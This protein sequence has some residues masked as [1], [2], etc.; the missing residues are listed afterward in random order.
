L[1]EHALKSLEQQPLSVT[2]ARGVGILVSRTLVLQL[3]TAGVTLVLARLLTPADYGLFALAIA[4]QSLAQVASGIG[5]SAA[6]IRQPQDPSAR[7]QRAVSGFLFSTGITFAAATAL[8]AFAL[9]PALGL[10]SDPLQMIAVTATAVPI[11]ALRTVPMVLLERHLRFGRVAVVETVETL[12]F[13][14]FALT[15]ALA[16]LGAYSLAGAVPVA[17]AGGLLAA[18][19]LQRPGAGIGLDFGAIRPLAHF[20]LRASALQTI[21]LARGVGFVTLITAIAGPATA[22]YYA[23]GTRL[24]AFPAALASAVQ[25]VSFP[26]LSRTPL[27]RP[28]RAARAAA[29]SA[30]LV[31]LPLAL[32]AGCSHTLVAVLLGDRWLPTV[33]LILISSPGVLL[34]ASSIPATVALALAQGRPGVPIAAVAGSAIAMAAVGLATVPELG[35]AGVGM[36]MTAGAGVNAAMLAQRAER[37]MQSATSS[38]AKALAIGVIA[39]ALGYLAPL[40]ETWLGLAIRIV[41]VTSVWA[42]LGLWIMRASLLDALRLV[43][44]LIP[45]RPARLAAPGRERRL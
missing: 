38:V 4:I 3:L 36:A 6:L 7:E 43:R 20:G 18:R 12:S 41:L 21:T 45:F 16:G 29:L 9:L 19:R 34:A 1:Q 17:A 5:L 42:S 37:E 22:G 25:R 8:L 23:M 32:L 27:E 11:Y 35:A 24:F 39:A 44:P 31:S 28:R 15:G 13:N 26:V 40:P 14:A 2:A 33:E 30:V 10:E